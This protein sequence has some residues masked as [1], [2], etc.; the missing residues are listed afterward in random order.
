MPEKIEFL[1]KKMQFDVQYYGERDGFRAF[2]RG[3]TAFLLDEAASKRWV[4]IGVVR[5]LFLLLWRG[6]SLKSAFAGWMEQH[7]LQRVREVV[8][9]VVTDCC[10]RVWSRDFLHCPL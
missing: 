2:V 7:T 10:G 5:G 3:E 6:V 9:Q 4:M 8:L 1:N